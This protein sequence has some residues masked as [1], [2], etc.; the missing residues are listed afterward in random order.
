MNGFLKF[1]VRILRVI[2]FGIFVFLF[3]DVNEI[4]FLVFELMVNGSDF[5]FMI[6]YWIFL[7]FLLFGLFVLIVSGNFVLGFKFLKNFSEYDGF[8]NFGLLLFVFLILIEIFVLVIC[9]DEL[10]WKYYMLNFNIGFVL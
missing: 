1:D 6:E 3:S 7:L 8:L 9:F 4:I 5:L 2:N 10:D